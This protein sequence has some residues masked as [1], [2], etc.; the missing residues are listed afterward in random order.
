MR[1]PAEMATCQIE[2]T[3]ACVLSCSNCTRFCG[4]SNSPFFLSMDQFRDAI[5]SLVEYAKQPHGV[6][7]IMGGE[8]LLHYKFKELCEY[9]LS[10]I[11]REHLGLWSTF[12][13]KFRHYRELIC[14]TFGN[15]LLNDHS[16]PDIF[17]APILMAS[18]DYF[19]DPREQALSCERCWCQESWSASINSKGAW[20]CEVAGALSE[21]FDGPEGWK[22]EPG[23]WKRSTMDFREQ[24]EWACSK[25]GCAMPIKRIRPS[26]DEH[27]DVSKSNLERLKQ[28]KSRKLAKGLVV[29]HDN[30]EFDPQL[31]QSGC[32]PVQTYK[33]TEFRQGIASRYGIVLRLNAMGYQEPIL[34]EEAG[35]IPPMGPPS[36]WSLFNNA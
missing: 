35:S 7:G 8:P 13:E 28:I 34:E 23:W 5:D 18:E 14:K 31:V 33:E 19:S 20:F 16:R 17:H 9:A 21:L 12:P 36:R 27:D 30:F 3:N 25:C 4:H 29:L 11:P 6:V 22:V 2:V 1:P 15:V 10:K 32:Y 24:R 26:Q